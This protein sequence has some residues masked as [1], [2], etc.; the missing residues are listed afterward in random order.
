[1]VLDRDLNA[2]RNLRSGPRRSGKP[3]PSHR[4]WMRPAPPAG[5]GRLP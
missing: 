3:A 5:N 4:A 1:M 2:A